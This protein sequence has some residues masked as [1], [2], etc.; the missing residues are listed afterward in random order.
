M[1]AVTTGVDRVYGYS[2]V[3]DEYALPSKSPPV[4]IQSELSE[5]LA[6]LDHG[7]RMRSSTDRALEGTC[8]YLTYVGHGRL[9]Q[10]LVYSPDPFRVDRDDLESRLLRALAPY[11]T[12]TEF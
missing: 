7:T 6:K 8:W 1:E 2:L 4:G 9:D 3:E 5:L 11:V 12:N 10:A